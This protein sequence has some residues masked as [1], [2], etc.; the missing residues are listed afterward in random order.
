[1]NRLR[2]KSLQEFAVA[3]KELVQM[4]LNG[5]PKIF[6]QRKAGYALVD[7][8]QDRDMKQHPFMGCERCLNLALN[9]DLKLEA[10]KAKL[11]EV[12]AGDPTRTR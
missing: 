5:L 1:M 3:G 2:G 4:A 9:Q 6:I 8:V 11:R 7:G 10:A 12:R